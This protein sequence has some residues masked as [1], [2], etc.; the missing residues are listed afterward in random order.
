MIPFL[1]PN[2]KSTKPLQT[3]LVS[4]DSVESLTGIDFFP[5][6]KDSIENRLERSADTYAWSFNN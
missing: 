6:L 2:E 1:I 5:E 3:Y 4:V